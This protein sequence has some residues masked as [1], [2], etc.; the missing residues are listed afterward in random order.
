MPLTAEQL[1]RAT[2]KCLAASRKLGLTQSNAAQREFLMRVTHLESACN[3]V[4]A[5][6]QES[7]FPE[8]PET[9]GPY[10]NG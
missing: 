10:A 7:M 2:L 8:T 9:K 4:L 5:P 3:E 1:A 6:K